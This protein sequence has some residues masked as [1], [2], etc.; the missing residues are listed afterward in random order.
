MKKLQIG[1][2]NTTRIINHRKW[3]LDLSTYVQYVHTKL[4]YI[5]FGIKKRRREYFYI[6]YNI[7]NAVHY[8]Q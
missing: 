5:H 7:C 2:T 3:L 1:D 6:K 8:R 4:L